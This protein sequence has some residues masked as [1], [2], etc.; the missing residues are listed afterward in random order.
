MKT[1]LLALSILMSSGVALADTNSTSLDLD[2]SYLELT[3]KE[4]KKRDKL[5]KPIYDNYEE[6]NVSSMINAIEKIFGMNVYENYYNSQYVGHERNLSDKKGVMENAVRFYTYTAN[7]KSAF[8][9][10]ESRVL[11]QKNTVV[12]ESTRSSCLNHKLT[13]GDKDEFSSELCLSSPY[14]INT[15]YEKEYERSLF[16]GYYKKGIYTTSKNPI[17]E[18]PIMNTY[19]DALNSMKLKA[20]DATVVFTNSDIF[21]EGTKLD[22]DNRNSAEVIPKRECDESGWRCQNVAPASKKYKVIYPDYSKLAPIPQPIIYISKNADYADIEELIAEHAH[23]IYAYNK[24]FNETL[25]PSIT[26]LNKVLRKFPNFLE[27]VKKSGKTVSRENL[28]NA[29]KMAML[30]VA[31]GTAIVGGAVVTGLAAVAAAPISLSVIFATPKLYT[32]FVSQ[33]VIFL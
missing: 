20:L 19:I 22:I 5:L 23:K 12:L 18:A 31:Y 2:L 24:L 32:L 7:S 15:Q 25:L 3:A 33:V 30:D 9:R 26:D 17:F 29:M 16:G 1:S 4:I 11:S 28:L 21:E 10:V 14:L 6:Q 8:D 13:K 27:D